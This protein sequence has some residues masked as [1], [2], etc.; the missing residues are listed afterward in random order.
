[1]FRGPKQVLR[2]SGP[3]EYMFDSIPKLSD[4][5]VNNLVDEIYAKTFKSFSNFGDDPERYRADLTKADLER[6]TKQLDVVVIGL[7]SPELHF[8]NRVVF[9]TMV[10]D[11]TVYKTNMIEFLH[12]LP[13][14]MP[15][16]GVARQMQRTTH[17]MET[18]LGRYGN[19]FYMS[20]DYYQLAEGKGD[21]L[22][23]L[24][25]IAGGVT[26]FWAHMG[27]NSM[28]N[29]RPRT[30]PQSLANTS[31][32][33]AFTECAVDDR[34][35][36]MLPLKDE[37]GLHQLLQRKARL[38]FRRTQIKPTMCFF[39]EDKRIILTTHDRYTRYDLAGPDGPKRLWQGEGAVSEIDGIALFEA[40]ALPPD[41]R[42]YDN[43]R[44]RR[45]LG[46]YAVFSKFADLAIGPN[47]TI[48][49]FIFDANCDEYVFIS[50]VDL[51]NKSQI[52][53]FNGPD[54]GQDSTWKVDYASIQRHSKMNGAPLEFCERLFHHKETGDPLY[55]YAN[56]GHGGSLYT[57]ITYT[58]VHPA[59]PP[60]QK[61]KK[62]T[63][64]LQQLLDEFDIIGW[65]CLVGVVT[66][67]CVL[68]IPGKQTGITAVSAGNLM[69]G[70][71]APNQ[72]HVVT[73]SGWAGIHIA[74]P[75]NIEVIND[76]F[77][78]GMLHGMNAGLLDETELYDL[79]RNFLM[80][81]N[82]QAPCIFIMVVRRNS[83]QEGPFMWT[84]GFGKFDLDDDPN[85]SCY[86]YPVYWNRMFGWQA[87][88][89]YASNLD[90][91]GGHCIAPICFKSSMQYTTKSGAT[92][93]LLGKT[94][95]G[96]FEGPGCA[97]VRRKGE[98]MN[99]RL[100]SDRA[101]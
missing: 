59:G 84:K 90:P 44:T 13:T 58:H 31:N 47:D 16:F 97:R 40:P 50:A 30:M 33:A 19:T 55:A 61:T 43:M 25:Q 82:E 93:E 89:P 63:F 95:W 88:D 3:R 86:E 1:M 8:I 12:Q 42:E 75:D 77:P 78:T 76:V 41:V 17:E 10:T 56:L 26:Q 99:P 46:E 14:P 37:T 9:P 80:L 21:M 92:K 23:N 54:L 27:M 22:L 6:L 18:R 45:R 11:N 69:V 72:S 28:L 48:G 81:E 100:M 53:A 68:V 4:E 49:W 64:T 96:P 15:E 36:F 20:N 65:R 98:V 24:S 52:F 66:N 71:D 73:W 60:G 87:C 35:N 62:T 39:P 94:H 34:D 101:K 70:E 79:K 85:R 32:R 74:N 67:P 7:M 29:S 38:M 83:Y 57:D 5:G 91:T 2:D 51:I